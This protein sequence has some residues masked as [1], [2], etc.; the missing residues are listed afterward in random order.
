MELLKESKEKESRGW[1]YKEITFDL[2]G[3]MKK[4]KKPAVREGMCPICLKALDKWNGEEFCCNCGFK[5]LKEEE[6]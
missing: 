6:D 4:R 5:K 3:N 2:G 1:I